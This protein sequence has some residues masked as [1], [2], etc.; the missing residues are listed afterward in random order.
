MIFN[1]NKKK[2]GGKKRKSLRKKSTKTTNSPKANSINS[3]D[4]NSQLNIPTVVQ[5]SRRFSNT[6]FK[7]PMD[8]GS[9]GSTI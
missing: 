2:K 3:Q 5:R 4:V 6:S 7:I 8:V 1:E 9:I